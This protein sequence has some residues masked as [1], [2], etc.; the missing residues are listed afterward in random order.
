MVQGKNFK[1][2]KNYK[3][4][5]SKEHGIYYRKD[6]I[7]VLNEIVSK[8]FN[9]RKHLK[10]KGKVAKGLEKGNSVEDIANSTGI[11][12]D[13][14]KSM[15]EEV[16]EEGLT[17]SYYDTH[18]MIRKILINSIYGVL[19]NRFF[20]FY[21][22]N[23]A[24]AITLGGQDLIKYLSNCTNQYFKNHWHKTYHKFFPEYADREVSPIKDDVVI[25]VDTDSNYICFDEVIKGLGIVFKDDEEYRQ[26]AI[27]FDKV[28]FE[29]FLD[30]ILN[31]YADKWGVEQVINFKREKI[32]TQKFTLAKKKYA[33]EVIDNEGEVYAEP[34]VKITGIEIVRTDTPQFCRTRIQ[35]VIDKIFKTKAADKQAILES[36]RKIH[37]EFLKADVSEIAIPKG[38]T[39]Y[40]KYA[41]PVDEYLKNGLKYPPH[42]PIHV[43][44][45][46][47]YNYI[48]AKHKLP[49]Q[50]I[51]NGTK[52]RFVHVAPQSN[53]LNQD[54]IGFVGQWPK[55]FNEMFTID[56]ERQWQRAFQNIIQRFFD[57]LDWSVINLEQN[58]L[59][60]MM[61]F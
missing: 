14:V 20:A 37:D 32:I 8:I 2:I 43:R 54:V 29:P 36:M 23:N 16:Q 26:W 7:G 56:Y 41:R 45:S 1:L 15:K 48:L 42:C 39:E 3:T 55:E 10:S 24:K 4:P 11:P 49:L 18:Q 50:P 44:A 17:S 28:F 46:I 52:L 19:A 57:V 47:N 12:L 22:V 21:N 6:K 34:K 59:M 51:F 58:T 61:E 9:E 40:T 25:L 5:L 38:V 30:K 27:K 35:S 13:L 53:D 33:D 60:Q 31:I